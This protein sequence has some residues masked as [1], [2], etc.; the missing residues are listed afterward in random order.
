VAL[1]EK[2]W[3]ALVATAWEELSRAGIA[4]AG[5]WLPAGRWWQGNAPEWDL[6]TTSPDGKRALVGECRAWKR[7]ATRS[8]LEPEARRLMSREL[9]A[10]ARGLE[11]TRALFVPELARGAPRKL[12]GVE[13][14]TVDDVV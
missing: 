11:V 2:S 7:P 13:V 9:P 6:V 3:P 5:D 12:D 4:G 10:P 1:L 14:L 8:M